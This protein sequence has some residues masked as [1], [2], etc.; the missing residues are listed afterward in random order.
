M[1][2]Q[3]MMQQGG[4]PGMG[5]SPQTIL[6]GMPGLQGIPP[7]QQPPQQHMGGMTPVRAG[8][9]QPKQS[10]S[11]PTPYTGKKRGPKVSS[12]SACL[13]C[14]DGTRSLP[15]GTLFVCGSQRISKSH[16]IRCNL[17]NNNCIMQLR[18]QPCHHRPSCFL[19]ISSRRPRLRRSHWQ[20]SS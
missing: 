18:R 10:T 9:M 14:F 7:P 8:M 13:V 19:S 1:A 11:T 5:V 17:H 4:M 15:Y 2:R 12:G 6:Y 16:L 3:M 20:V